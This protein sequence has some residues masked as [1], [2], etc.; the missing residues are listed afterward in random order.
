MAAQVQTIESGS[1]L[2]EGGRP[3]IKA[4]TR[5]SLA[6]TEIRSQ[7]MPED[8]TLCSYE[9]LRPSVNLCSRL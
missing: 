5:N 9:D 3:L 6:G 1:V 8:W 7:N 2:D 4:S